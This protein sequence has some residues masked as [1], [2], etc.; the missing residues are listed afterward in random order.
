[1]DTSF[2]L[3]GLLS[4]KDSVYGLR[5]PLSFEQLSAQKAVAQFPYGSPFRARP[6]N[7]LPG[8][9]AIHGSRAV[10]G[11]F[12]NRPLSP[13]IALKKPQISATYSISHR[14]FG[15]VVASVIL[16][17]PILMKYSLTF[18]V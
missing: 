10:S 9:R 17:S 6:S 13:H 14:I 11:A 1:M 12:A 18:D 5:R 8:S 15:G 2:A 4:G 16:A 3:R 7:A